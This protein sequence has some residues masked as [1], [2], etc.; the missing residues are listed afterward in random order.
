M[1]DN[2]DS[3]E[4][5][6]QNIAV[7]FA[8]TLKLHQRIAEA[9]DKTLISLSAGA[10]VLS[11]T[12]ITTFTPGKS[13]LPVLFSSWLCFVVSI[14]CVTIATRRAQIA[15][16]RDAETLTKSMRELDEKKKGGNLLVDATPQIARDVMVAR[17]NNL[18]IVAFLFGIL[19]LGLFVGFNLWQSKPT[20]PCIV[21]TKSQGLLL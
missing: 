6:K 8:D 7:L 21:F 16:I 17:L 5:A 3:F 1:A 18:A 4:K 12:F 20:S 13:L 14:S 2:E 19:L 10:L 11:M 9:L 15:T